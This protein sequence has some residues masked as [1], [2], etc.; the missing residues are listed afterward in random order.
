MSQ[1]D[2]PEAIDRIAAP[3]PV[4]LGMKSHTG[5]AAV[6]ALAGPVASAE[7]VAKRRIDMATTF[8]EGAVYHKSQE[9]SVGQ[10]EALIRASEEK[11]E[12]LAREALMGLA[13]ELRAAGCEPVATGLVSGDG[14]GLPPLASIL[15]SHALVHAAEGELYRQVLLR[16]SEACHIRAIPIPAKEIEARAAG[17]LG[18]TRAR[19]PARL[20]EL[21]NASGRPWARDQKESALAA[22]VALAARRSD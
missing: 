20:A 16:A 13:A 18:I 14:R 17:A 6:V 2:R 7:V 1:K 11:F 4:S 8:D 15:K 19:L 21:G 5:W 9:L 3:R 10:A 12:R 22:W